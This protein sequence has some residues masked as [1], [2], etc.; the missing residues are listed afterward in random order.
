MADPHLLCRD[1]WVTLT[2]CVLGTTRIKLGPGV[3]G[4]HA[5]H[6]SVT[7]SAILPQ[8]PGQGFQQRE[9]ILRMFAGDVMARVG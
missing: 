3:T 8:V 7:A 4:P 1:L 6:A 5:R 9:E 2:A